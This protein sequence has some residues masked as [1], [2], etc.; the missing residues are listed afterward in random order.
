LQ[1]EDA[2]SHHA[3]PGRIISVL[4]CIEN[5]E[6]DEVMGAIRVDDKR[7]ESFVALQGFPE[8]D[9]HLRSPFDRPL[10]T[11]KVGISCLHLQMSSAEEAK[12][13]EITYRL[14]QN[15]GHA[16]NE[17]LKV[18]RPVQSPKVMAIV[19]LWRRPATILWDWIQ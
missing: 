12:T 2:H 1:N 10:A 3:L 17:E 6:D 19:I 4:H 11:G 5:T 9:E 8:K 18:L 7:P 14:V 15:P 16:V 13:C